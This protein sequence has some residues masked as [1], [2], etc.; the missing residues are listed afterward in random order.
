M[1]TARLEAF[2]DGV[3]AIII[4]IMVLGLQAPQGVDFKSLLPLLPK[5]FS[6]LFSFLYVGIYWNNHHHLFQRLSKCNGKVL[7][8]NLNLLFWLSFIPFTT[9]WMGESKFASN[10]VTLYC[11][12]LLMAAI[13]FLILEKSAVAIEGKTSEFGEALNNHQKELISL[14]CYAVSVFVSF[15]WPVA[16]VVI[17]YLIALIWLIPD[18]RLES[19]GKEV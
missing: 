11:L 19:I 9:D 10:P 1:T 17:V 14:G 7:L 12:N 15:F 2:S 18:K 3:L 8:A 5:V 6:Y 16:S 4:T 13:S